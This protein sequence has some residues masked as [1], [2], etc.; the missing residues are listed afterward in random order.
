MTDDN[1]TLDNA[2]ESLDGV[3]SDLKRLAE[4]ATDRWGDEWTIE[5]MFHGDGGSRMFAVSGIAAGAGYDGDVSVR[6][7]LWV[8]DAGERAVHRVHVRDEEVLEE[9]PLFNEFEDP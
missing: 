4:A 9:E 1:D 2:V 8:N 5:A 6:E 3:D 7:R